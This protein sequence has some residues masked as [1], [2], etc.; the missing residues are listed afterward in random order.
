MT[1]YRSAVT[2]LFVSEAFAKANPRET[3]AVGDD[4]PPDHSKEIARLEFKLAASQSL[5]S[6]YSDRIREIEKRLAELRAAQEKLTEMR[7]L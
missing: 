4:G 2:G 3:V 5:G 6:G 1:R 7:A